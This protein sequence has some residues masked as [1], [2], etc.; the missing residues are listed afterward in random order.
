MAYLNFSKRYYKPGT[1]RYLE[2]QS[3]YR[4]LDPEVIGKVGYCLDHNESFGLDSVDGCYIVSTADLIVA[5]FNKTRDKTVVYMP[6]RVALE[7]FISTTLYTHTF[8]ISPINCYKFLLAVKHLQNQQHDQIGGRI[9][10]P[11]NGRIEDAPGRKGV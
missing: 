4:D 1:K 11:D 6:S 5:H 9:I 10:M 8:F 3:E 7:M 2:M